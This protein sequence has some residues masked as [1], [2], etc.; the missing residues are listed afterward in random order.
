MLARP[1]RL[2][3]RRCL[4]IAQGIV[5]RRRPSLFESM[6]GAF[7]APRGGGERGIALHEALSGGTHPC[8][9]SSERVLRHSRASRSLRELLPSLSRPPPPPQ[10]I[11]ELA[12]RD[13]AVEEFSCTSSPKWGMHSQQVRGARLPPPHVHLVRRRLSR[14]GFGKP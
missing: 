7:C 11:L 3:A 2:V 1:V 4:G 6:F 5:I 9:G 10:A 12:Q 13:N 14:D 8:I